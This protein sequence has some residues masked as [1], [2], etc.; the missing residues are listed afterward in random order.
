MIPNNDSVSLLSQSVEGMDLTDLYLTYSQLKEKTI[1]T[2][3]DCSK[4][5]HKSKCKTLLEERV[6]KLQSCSTCFTKKILKEL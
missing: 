1:Y 2:S 3:E 5:T 6:E 4:C